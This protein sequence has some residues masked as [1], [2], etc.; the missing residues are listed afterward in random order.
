M[1]ELRRMAY[2]EAM[3]VDS[4]VSRRQ[5]PGAAVTRRLVI[6]P[7]RLAPP[8]AQQG[9]GSEAKQALATA[10]PTPLRPDL[11][12]RPDVTPRTRAGTKDAAPGPEPAQAAEP[13]PQFSLS[14]IVAGDWLWLEELAGMPLTTEQVQLVQSMAAALL[15]RRGGGS[16][17][18]ASAVGAPAAKPEVT[19]FDWPIHTNRQL[20]LGEQAARASVAA[21]VSRRLE[22]RGCRGVVLLGQSTAQRVPVS[23]LMIPAVRTASTVAILARP[24]LKRQV[25]QD[26]QPLLGD[27]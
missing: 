1:N 8:A 21:F 16:E 11:G 5:L 26:L 22:Q 2:L 14:A 19:Q 17:N 10:A 24:T 7:T 25:W 12:S 4:Y 27:S 18:A 15:R 23:E 20:D 6:V 13:V 3:G 9:A